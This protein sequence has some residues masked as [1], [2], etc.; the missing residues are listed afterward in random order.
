MEYFEL[1]QSKKVEHPIEV[2][3]LEKEKYSYTMTEQEYE[4][5]DKLIVAYFLGHASEEICDIL[6]KPT[7]LISD[8][9][10][11]VMELYE[12]EME[13]KG[14]QLFPKEEEC[15]QYPLYWVPLF[16]EEKCLHKD[17]VFLD[18]GMISKLILDQERIGNRQ[19]LRISDIL[20]YKVIVSLP[21][22]E[23]ILRR[24]LYGIGIQKIEVR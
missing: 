1:F 10:K 6:E 24:R 8:N 23:S 11:N 14:V 7:F 2:I 5:L 22:A 4:Q 21:V 16:H 15:K 9:L 12:K 13:F 18:N 3:G 17:T 19:I 20:E